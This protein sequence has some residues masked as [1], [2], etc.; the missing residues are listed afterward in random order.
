M[1]DQYRTVEISND[2]ADYISGPTSNQLSR[3]QGGTSRDGT[4]QV[5]ADQ[6]ADSGDTSTSSTR[7]RKA[8]ASS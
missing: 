7:T 6:S 8:S 2:P 3:T 1:S 4:V 5:V